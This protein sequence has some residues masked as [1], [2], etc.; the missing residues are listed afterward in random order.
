MD[1]LARVLAETALDDLLH[2]RTGLNEGPSPRRTC[3]RNEGHGQAAS[4]G[5]V[6][7]LTQTNTRRAS[8][9]GPTRR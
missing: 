3:Q 2:D 6:Q 9:S 8:R 5:T 1:R 4:L 7:D